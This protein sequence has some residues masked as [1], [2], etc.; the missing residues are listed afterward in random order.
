MARIS[1]G[2]AKPLDVDNTYLKALEEQLREA[3]LEGDAKPYA[4]AL[5]WA[6][7]DPD[8]ERGL[9]ASVASGA[10]PKALLTVLPRVAQEIYTPAERPPSP[11][12]IRPVQAP[13]YPFWEGL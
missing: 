10:W 4:V 11:K 5:V 8:Y 12:S 6:T 13:A 9:R 1:F 7:V 2:G 3:G